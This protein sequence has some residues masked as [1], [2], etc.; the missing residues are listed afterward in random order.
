MHKSIVI[1]LLLFLLILIPIAAHSAAAQEEPLN[2]EATDIG[3][4]LG[5]VGFESGLPLSWSS[6]S[7]SDRTKWGTMDTCYGIV[8]EQFE[9]WTGGSGDTMCAEND[10]YRFEEY[11]ARLISNP[12]T[13]PAGTSIANLE[14]K[15]NYQD[16]TDVAE[17]DYF[18]LDISTDGGGNWANLIHWN[19]DHGVQADLP[20]ETVTVDLSSY[21][22]Q[23]VHIR[24]RYYDLLHEAWDWYAQVDDVNFICDQPVDFSDLSPAVA[25]TAGHSNPMPRTLWLGPLVE[26]D[27]N[28]LEGTDYSSDDGVNVTHPWQPGATALLNVMVSGNPG[29][30]AGWVDWDNSGTFE[31]PDELIVD[32][33]VTSGLNGVTFTV[34][35]TYGPGPGSVIR[36][37]FR[38]YPSEPTV[39][40][41]NSTVSPIGVVSDGEVE[42]YTWSFTAT[43]VGLAQVSGSAPAPWLLPSL[44]FAAAL[45]L[46]L[47]GIYTWRRRQTH[48]R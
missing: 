40:R 41:I 32:Q 46:L 33:A 39:S 6:S 48:H 38:L 7:T 9:N 22:G 23:T 3:C 43:A 12:F 10:S 2:L 30:L 31:N 34:S 26:D 47:L 13:I 36:S 11:D 28:D 25:G 17:R 8:I 24:W 5:T 15:T 18:D 1:W 37:R 19:E 29:W 44:G 42:D 20:G 4:N 16:V 27:A 21:T 14:Y 45:I 35:N